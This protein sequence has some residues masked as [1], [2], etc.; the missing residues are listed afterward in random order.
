MGKNEILQKEMLIWLFL[1]HKL[2]DFWVP[3]TLPPPCPSASH[4][5]LHL[6]HTGPQAPCGGAVHSGTAF[7][8]R[9]TSNSSSSRN[10]ERNPF[11]QRL[12]LDTNASP[13]AT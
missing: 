1:V 8:V 3:G 10:R 5:S 6:R 7:F 13:Q 2:L 4:P 9:G 11:T 12:G